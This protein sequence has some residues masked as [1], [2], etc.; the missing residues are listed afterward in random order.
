VHGRSGDPVPLGDLACSA[1]AFGERPAVLEGVKA[2][3]R[4]SGTAD[5]ARSSL[6]I[7]ATVCAPVERGDH[8]SRPATPRRPHDPLPRG[9]PSHFDKPAASTSQAELLNPRGH[10]PSPWHAVDRE[11]RPAPQRAGDLRDRHLT[12]LLE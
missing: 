8:A 2:A 12:P 9:P 1:N 10:A 11:Q 6:V 5:T 4:G 3:G 7:Q